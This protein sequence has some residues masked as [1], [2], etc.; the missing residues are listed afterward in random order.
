MESRAS[1][2]DS[3]WVIVRLPRAFID[4]PKMYLTSTL[5]D[6]NL[7]LAEQWPS[8]EAAEAALAAHLKLHPDER[9][10]TWCLTDLAIELTEAAA[11]YE[12]PPG[13]PIVN[14]P[15]TEAL[16]AALERGEL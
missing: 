7:H 3:V 16:L 11:V 8:E 15:V 10:V 2:L 1:T 13:R 5:W 12:E 14:D 4:E 9:A 6:L